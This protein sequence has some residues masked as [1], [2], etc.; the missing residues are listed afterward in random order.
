MD[1]ETVQQRLNM[2]LL[3]DTNKEFNQALWTAIQ[4]LKTPPESEATKLLHICHLLLEAGAKVPLFEKEHWG[5][6]CRPSR[7][8]KSVPLGDMGEIVTLCHYSCYYGHVNLLTKVQNALEKHEFIQTAHAFVTINEVTEQ[9]LLHAVQNGHVKCMEVLLPRCCTLPELSWY[10]IRLRKV[11]LCSCASGPSRYDLH[12]YPEHLVIRLM[13]FCK[14][15]KPELLSVILEMCS[16]TN[17]RYHLYRQILIA[18][19]DK[20]VPMI[21]LLLENYKVLNQPDFNQLAIWALERNYESTNINNFETNRDFVTFLYRHRRLV[22]IPVDV[23]HT[24]AAQDEAWLYFCKFAANSEFPS[25]LLVKVA[26]EGNLSCLHYILQDGFRQMIDLNWLN[27]NCCDGHTALT[28]VS[29]RYYFNASVIEKLL[30]FDID[31]NKP[32]IHGQFPLQALINSYY[33]FDADK[34]LEAFHHAFIMLIQYGCDIKASLS[35]TYSADRV[36]ILSDYHALKNTIC[37]MEILILAEM[38]TSVYYNFKNK[39]ISPGYH[40]DRYEDELSCL[41]DEALREPW[42]LRDQCRYRIR[43]SLRTNIPNKIAK[44]AGVLPPALRD[45][46]LLLEIED[47]DLSDPRCVWKKYKRS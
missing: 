30:N 16:Q 13:K 44:L 5:L 39:L 21:A 37:M 33:C 22:K 43:A 28:I 12:P 19:N 25:S 40:R 27:G 36:N 23:M 6:Y 46:L 41:I 29:E 18:L 7:H 17:I 32:N 45:Y 31:T 4:S 8:K 34:W 14:R 24:P 1:V 38:D 9:P 2:P 20:K 47:T 15:L 35:D 42:S 3:V 26:R 11:A 10:M